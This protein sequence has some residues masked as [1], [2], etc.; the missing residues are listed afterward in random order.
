MESG[1]FHLS[2]AGWIRKDSEP[3]PPDRQETWRYELE[4][5]SDDTKDE[6]TLTR[7]WMSKGMTDAQSIALHSLHGEAIEPTLER[8][9][10]LYCRV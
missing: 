5:P 9:V 10:T 2:S 3:P 7:I 6:V 4:R 8:N 1:Y